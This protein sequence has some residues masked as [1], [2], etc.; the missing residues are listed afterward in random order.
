MQSLGLLRKNY[1]V[2]Y[3]LIQQVLEHMYAVSVV[4]IWK[5]WLNL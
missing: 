4:K 2:Y 5:D 3:H 1:I